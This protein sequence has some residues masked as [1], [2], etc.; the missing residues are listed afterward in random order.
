MNYAALLTLTLGLAGCSTAE[1]ENHVNSI[2]DIAAETISGE[3]VKLEAYKGK[4]L[5]IVNTASKCGFTGQYDGLQTLY[6]TYRDQGFEILGFP[7]NDFLKQEPGSNEEIASFCKLNY[8]V[9]FPMFGKISVKGNDQ[10]PLYTYLT[11]KETNPEHG[12]K[13][14]WNFN[15]F[16]ISRS[17]EIVGRFGSRTKPQDTAL[18]AAV[19]KELNTP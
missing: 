16:L 5:L 11:S 14:S 1:K 4:A 2:Y 7:S 9:T 3:T 19:E 8:G 12:G 17:G 13:I 15:K 6:E 10:H 18:I